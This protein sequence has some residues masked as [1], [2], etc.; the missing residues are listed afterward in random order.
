MGGRRA[1]SLSEIVGTGL[2]AQQASFTRAIRLQDPEGIAASS[3]KLV[4][5]SE[6]IS[7][8]LYY[9]SKLTDFVLKEAKSKQD[10]DYEQR[11]GLARKEWSRFKREEGIEDDPVVTNAI[12][13]AVAKAIGKGRT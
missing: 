7:D 1:K 4:A 8:I 5:E 3:A 12:V 10:L 11:I 13:S 9:A 6:K 2:G